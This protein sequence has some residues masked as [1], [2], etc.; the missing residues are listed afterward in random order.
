MKNRKNQID[1]KNAPANYVQIEEFRKMKKTN[2]SRVATY[3]GQIFAKIFGISR[4]SQRSNYEK[5]EAVAQ[6]EFDL[7]KQLKLRK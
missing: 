2:V 6:Q 5:E 7:K 1:S 3:Q 4:T